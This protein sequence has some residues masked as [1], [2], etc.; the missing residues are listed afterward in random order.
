MKLIQC[1]IQPHKLNEVVT[2]LQPVA[3]GMI[4]SEV[5]GHGQQKGHP[6]VYRGIEYEVTLVPKAMIEIVVDDNKVDDIVD[7][8]IRTSRTGRI[9]DGRIFVIP[10]EENYHVRTGF[11]DMD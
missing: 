6:V 8:V 4:V 9:G 2:A 10:I 7:V 3:P 5:R 1:I 11:M